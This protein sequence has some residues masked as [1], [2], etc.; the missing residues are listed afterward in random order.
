MHSHIPASLLFKTLW[1]RTRYFPLITRGLFRKHIGVK[2]DMKKAEGIATKP[3]LQI[4]LRI[5]NHC[6]QHCAICGQFGKKGYMNTPDG[7]R[8]LQEIP[9]SQYFKLV[10]ELAFLTMWIKL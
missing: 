1:G 10:D 9:V 2:S 8:L 6:N 5:T 3:P 7:L 4:S